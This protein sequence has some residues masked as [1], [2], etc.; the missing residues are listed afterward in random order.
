[1]NIN[2]QLHGFF[3]VRFGVFTCF[4]MLFKDPSIDLVQIYGVQNIVFP[5]AWYKGFPML[6]S[7][8]FQQAWSRVNCVNLIAANLYFPRLNFTGSGIYDCGEVKTYIYDEEPIEKRLLFATL[9][10]NS[11]QPIKN[12]R[13]YMRD[14]TAKQHRRDTEMSEQFDTDRNIPQA[15][16]NECKLSVFEDEYHSPK[17]FKSQ[18]AGNLFTL[19]KLATP[20]NELSICADRSMLQ[21]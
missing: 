1:M 11:R 21:P 5:T 3:Q 9:S 12:D 19:A 18:I 16:D 10:R 4:D 6:I 15:I 2:N 20:S 14:H 17:T 8:E 13:N 7:I